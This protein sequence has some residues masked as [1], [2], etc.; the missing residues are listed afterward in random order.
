[1]SPPYEI[2]DEK[3]DTSFTDEPGAPNQP[4]GESQSRDSEKAGSFAGQVATSPSFTQ[5]GGHHPL[6]GHP[7]S[8][9]AEIPNTGGAPEGEPTRE[10]GCRA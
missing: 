5:V 3:T 6:G 7:E 2:A 1:M 4:F 8:P 9:I 10:T